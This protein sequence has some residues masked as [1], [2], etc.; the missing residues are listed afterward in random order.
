MIK[1]FWTDGACS[2]NPGSGGWAA[3][4]LNEEVSPPVIIEYYM[5]HTNNTTNNRMEMEAVL[6]V[7][8]K[9]YKDLDNEYIIHSDSAYVVN[10]CNDWIWKWAANGWKRSKNKEIENLHLVKKIY[11][12]MNRDFPNFQIIKCAGHSGKIGNELA[13][14]LASSN[15][16]KFD[17][18]LK[19]NKITILP[20]S[21]FIDKF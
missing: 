13:D 16:D 19:N 7:L 9:A 5:E 20:D 6:Y 21:I 12:Y 8:K 1:N 10:M 18:I 2:G 4:E 14:A 15:I 11:K 17:K 3:I